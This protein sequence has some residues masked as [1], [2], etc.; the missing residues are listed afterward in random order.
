MERASDTHWI[1]VWVGPRA[2]L[3][4]VVKRKIPS[5]AG[6]RTLV[7]RSSGSLPS[8]LKFRSYID[9]KKSTSV[10][11]ADE[12]LT[13]DLHS[14]NHARCHYKIFSVTHSLSVLSAGTSNVVFSL[15]HIVTPPPAP[16]QPPIQWVRGALTLGVKR[17]GHE[18]ATHLHLV[19]GSKTRGDIPSLSNTSSWRGV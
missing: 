14:R 16:S 15:R 18:A 10:Q 12:I 2:V 17:S 1:G 11:F 19:P 7:P 8:C 5:P 3:D 9:H 6:N 13:E 4:A